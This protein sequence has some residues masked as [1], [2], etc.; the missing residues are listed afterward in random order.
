MKAY[1]D[2]N[3]TTRIFQNQDATTKADKIIDFAIIIIRF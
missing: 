2:G 3:Y 1:H